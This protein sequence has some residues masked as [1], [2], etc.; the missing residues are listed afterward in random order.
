MTK[1]NKKRNVGLVYE[2]LLRYITE[3]II[4]NDQI[5]AKK[6]TKIIER[7]FKKGTELYKEF[8][9]FN[10]LANSTISGT[11]IAASILTEAKTAARS[12]DVK[13]LSSEKSLLIK[14]IN[15][16]LKS[17]NFFHQRI[18]QY[19]TYATI[20][21]MLNEWRADK[22][23]NLNKIIEYEKKIVEH[24][25]DEK[26]NI[27]R[28]YEFDERSDRLV[29]NVLSE[30][31]NKKYNKKLTPEQ[32]DIIRNYAIYS[33]DSS[34]MNVYLT[35][36]KSKTLKA[37]NEF[38][39]DCKNKFLLEKFD[40]VKNQITDLPTAGVDDETIKKFLT[41]SMLKEQLLRS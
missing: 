8:R 33:E 13:K 18:P 39:A 19:K 10:A 11:H 9:L 16:Q 5:G 26:K 15:Y 25:L 35:N 23:Y 38:K 6:A 32:K 40:N 36:L 14:D 22:D 28:N 21:T 7:R 27:V 12:A 29:F 41:V 37:L 17:E 3:S 31:I 30:K 4:D 34:A 1:H 20:Q 24:L 2:M